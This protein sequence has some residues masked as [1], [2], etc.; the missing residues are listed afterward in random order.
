MPS[1]S[2]KGVV[3]W[4]K[5]IWDEV[6][7]KITENSFTGSTYFFEDAVEYSRDTESESEIELEIE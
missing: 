3:V 4:L 1:P 7:I 2:R 5:E 6:P